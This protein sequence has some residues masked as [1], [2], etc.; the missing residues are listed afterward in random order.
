MPVQWVNR[1]DLDF[2]GFAGE[3]VGGAVR[4]G[5]RVRV[6]PSGTREHRRA[7][8]SPP[9]ATS[10]EAVAGQSVTLTLADEIDISRGDVHRRGDRRRPRVADQFECHLVWMAEEPMLPGRPYLLKIGA[11]TVG[12]TRRRTP[13]TR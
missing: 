6:V 8:S 12:A 4:P 9:T 2:R 13:S 1:P 5:D 7:G 11:R 3:I 10:T